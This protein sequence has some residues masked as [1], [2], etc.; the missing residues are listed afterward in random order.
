MP[1]PK[2]LGYIVLT[3]FLDTDFSW[4]FTLFEN[5]PNNDIKK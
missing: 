1:R 5:F 3:L 4:P 2:V